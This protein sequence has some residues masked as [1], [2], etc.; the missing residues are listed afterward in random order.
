[1][2]G[3]QDEGNQASLYMESD[4][5][6]EKLNVG[7]RTKFQLCVN[8]GGQAETTNPSGKSDTKVSKHFRAVNNEHPPKNS[9]VK[10]YIA[11]N[12][13]SKCPGN[14]ILVDGKMTLVV[15][16]TRFV[17]DRNIFDSRPNTMLTRMF[18]SCTNY[19]NKNDKGEFVVAQGVSSAV[20][21][22]ILDYYRVGVITC[23][24]SISIQELREACDY[25]LIP[26]NATVIKCQNLRDLLHELSNDGAKEQ[27]RG[28]L[29]INIL[30]LMV[31]A[32]K[33]GRRECHIVVLTNDDVVEWDEEYP[34]S[35]GEDDTQIVYSTELNRFLKYFENRDV[36]KDVL[37]ERG[38]KK[39]R[40]G[41][42][43]YPTT[44]E[45]VR[46]RHNSSRPE[47]I[48][49]YVQRA[50][51]HMSWEKEVSKSRHVDFQCVKSKVGNNVIGAVDEPA[52]LAA[53]SG[54]DS[55]P[56]PPQV[57]LGSEPED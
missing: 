32:A 40:L 1:M 56:P 27:F 17:V 21:K 44:K 18:S 54:G 41:N 28:Y 15:D 37:K 51:I 8:N 10:H 22:C 2:A 16:D 23:P 38:L 7:V 48:Y 35:M 47:V 19:S 24:P 34:P 4:E 30:P 31:Q 57:L 43:G 39:I 29:E 20:F 49:N 55:V 42:E 26:F 25:L 46:Q 3:L 53:S 5:E 12:R 6:N 45:K 13:T 33:M 9:S 36:A 11:P 52:A 50:F 14:K